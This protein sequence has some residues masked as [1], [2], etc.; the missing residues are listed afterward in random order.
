MSLAQD[1]D[2]KERDGVRFNYP[3][4]AAKLIYAG[5]LVCLN[6]TGYL[7]PGAVA[8]TLL[9]VGRAEAQADNSGGA[10]GAL[11]CD[12]KRG[13]FRWAN[14]AAGDA[15]ASTDIGSVCYVVDD[16][17]VAKT[18]GTNTRSLA[19]RVID[20]DVLGVWVDHRISAA[21]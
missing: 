16:Q 2:T 5:A 11:T 7:V 14:S 4:G 12:V 9:C 13:V 21:A 17:T 20:V 18:N 6:A 15:I 3:V 8:T 19:G 1:R 10:D